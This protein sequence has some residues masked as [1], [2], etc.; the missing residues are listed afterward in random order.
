MNKKEL[1]KDITKYNLFVAVREHVV[2]FGL[3]ATKEEIENLIEKGV[4]NE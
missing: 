2:E 1:E 4:E 3:E